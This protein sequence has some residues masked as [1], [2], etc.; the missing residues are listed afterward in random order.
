MHNRITSA[1]VREC[2]TDR[3]L[4]I[5]PS[6]QINFLQCRDAEGFLLALAGLFGG[7]P[8]NCFCEREEYEVKAA[9]VWTDGLSCTLGARFSKEDKAVWVHSVDDTKSGLAMPSPE[10]VKAI[11]KRRFR[12]GTNTTHIF[13]NRSKSGSFDTLGESDE[14]LRRFQRFLKETQRRSL[15]G[16]MRPVFLFNFLERLDKAV[17]L[18]TIFNMLNATDRQVFIA[19]PHYYEINTLEEMPYDTAIHTL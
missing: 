13:D 3:M 8:D 18:K 16:D 10:R 4:E 1:L 15:L 2:R 12:N 17:D 5:Q 9:V 19:V 7:L 6:T 11:H 14:T